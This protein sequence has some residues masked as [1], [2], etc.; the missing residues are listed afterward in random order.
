MKKPNF[1]LLKDAYEIIDG[2]PEENLNLNAWRTRN[3]GATCGTIACAAGW[4]TLHPKFQTLGLTVHGSHGVPKYRDHTH[5]AALAA[6]FE[7][8]T[9]DAEV[10]FKTALHDARKSHKEIFRERVRDFLEKHG[11]LKEQLA[12]ANNAA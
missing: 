9:D 8:E 7:I 1:E 5:Y 3:R 11:Q 2:I 6:L 10:L 12:E 4:L